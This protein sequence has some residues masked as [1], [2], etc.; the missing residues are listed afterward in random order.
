MN[1]RKSLENLV[2]GWLPQ[3]PI[4]SSRALPNQ[5]KTGRIRII[6]QNLLLVFLIIGGLFSALILIDSWIKFVLFGSILIGG[7]AWRFSHGNVRKVFKFLVVAVLIFSISFTTVEIILLGNAGYPP[8]YNSDQP[9]I[10]FSTA[11]IP[12][13]LLTKLVQDIE[14][15]PTYKFLTVQFGETTAET[16][17]LDTAFPSRGGY[18]QVDF[19]GKNSDAYF[20]FSS[21]SG[22]PYHLNVGISK[23]TLTTRFHPQAQSAKD[24]FSQIDNL[25]LQW[26]YNRALEI[27]QNKTGS[28]PK[29]DALSFTMTFEDNGYIGYDGT[30]VSYEGITVQ[31]TGSLNGRGTL[32]AD[33]E[34]NGTLIYMTQPQ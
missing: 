7:L 26:F 13:V 8:T 31:L 2:R 34:P 22:Y 10:T 12:S 6:F 16:I 33:F 4:L 32:I 23:T 5:K 9:N 1:A 21:S 14:R 29:I 19:Y 17:K 24:S 27:A 15:T 25:G 3:D 28:V 30:Q 18:V 20:Y 11:N